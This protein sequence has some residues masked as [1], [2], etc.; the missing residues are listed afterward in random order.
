MFLVH[1]RRQVKPQTAGVRSR[2]PV[3]THGTALGGFL[4]PFYAVLFLA[5]SVFAG[6]FG[7]A[8]HRVRFQDESPLGRQDAEVLSFVTGTFVGA[9]SGICFKNDPVFGWTLVVNSR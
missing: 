5:M 8:T 1:F 9:I 6:A 2:Q 3:Q 7:G 4:A